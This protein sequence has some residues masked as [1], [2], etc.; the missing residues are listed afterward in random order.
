MRAKSTFLPSRPAAVRRVRI[1][2]CGV[3]HP[4]AA[5]HRMKVEGPTR[6]LRLCQASWPA[7]ISAACAFAAA[8][9]LTLTP[10]SW[11][12]LT[13]NMLPA[14]IAT[15][16]RVIRSQHCNWLSIAV[17]PLPISQ[18]MPSTHPCTMTSHMHQSVICHLRR[19]TKPIAADA[20][21]MAT[22]AWAMMIAIS[23]LPRAT[24]TTMQ[25]AA[26][27][28]GTIVLSLLPIFSPFAKSRQNHSQRYSG[29][30]SGLCD[31]SITAML[32]L[33]DPAK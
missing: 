2:G 11:H 16:H 24:A 29:N 8:S 25:A 28:N 33:R 26:A 13:S 10:S 19:S 14:S 9:S 18:V 23:D 6:T 1:T 27:T 5:G 32:F 30:I 22:T 12:G 7:P 4:A 20:T 15:L 17:I 31:T 21:H 3:A